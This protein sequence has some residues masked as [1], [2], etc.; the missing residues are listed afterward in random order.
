MSED[1][2]SPQPGGAG[3]QLAL[4]LRRLRRAHGLSQRAL[5]RPLH[6]NAHSAIADYEAGRRIP[7]ADVLRDYERFFG[8]AAGALVRQRGRAIAERAALE[9]P[10]ARPRPRDPAAPAVPRQLPAAPACLVGRDQALAV[11]DA[12]L[13]P[14]QPPGS[15]PAR[16]PGSQPARAPGTQPA[17]PPGVV[18]VSGMGGVGKTAL[19][20]WWAYRAQGAFPAGTLYVNLQGYDPQARPLAPATALE[21]FLRALG[22]ANE[23]IPYHA[24]ER[25]ALLRT[26][27]AGRRGR[28]TLSGRC[29]GDRAAAHG[30][31]GQ[32]RAYADRDH[33][34]Q[35]G[36]RRCLARLAFEPKGAK[37]RAGG[38]N[39]SAMRGIALLQ[40]PRVSGPARP[41]LRRSTRPPSAPPAT[42][43]SA[44]WAARSPALS[45][46]PARPVSPASS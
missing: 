43:V 28:R 34:S 4:T 31:G 42:G 46:S 6:L 22:V 30:R 24:A 9:G 36:R 21:G 33:R 14:G 35:L 40:P 5:T 3:A 2:Q 19:A 39:W 17:Q 20:V 8:L 41:P 44:K 45:L 32:A 38:S 12:L 37:L 13:P 10:P 1:G 23:R 26:L 25:A 27:T 29:A 18:A 16:G 15:Q 7:P 11:L